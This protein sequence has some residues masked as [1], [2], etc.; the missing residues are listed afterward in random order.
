M[1]CTNPLYALIL[2]KSKE[3]GKYK[4]RFLPRR[5]DTNLA[6]LEE[7]YGLDN[8][9]R[10][11]CGKC[12]SCI[13]TYRKNWSV[14]CKLEA[15]CHLQNCFVTLTY[16][17]SHYNENCANRKEDLQKFIHA[18][19]DSGI[20]FRY[21]ACGELGSS[22][23]RFHYHMIMFGYFPSD[24]KPLGKKLEGMYFKSDFLTRKWNKGMVIVTEMSE[25]CA[26]YVAG[27]VN[28]KTSEL[29]KQNFILMST[30]PGIAFDY[31]LS[32]KEEMLEYGVILG[33]KGAVHFIPKYGNRVLEGE[34]AL[35]LFKANNMVDMRVSEDSLMR[36]LNV[37]VRE[38]TFLKRDKDMRDK[39]LKRRRVL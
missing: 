12:A 37:D 15:K 33:D 17:N 26:E 32:H 4:L 18:L 1:S 21:F 19:R 7:R 10:I 38:K 39:L 30:R 28:K 5:V 36:E 11:P 24:A 29:D 13:L 35:E 6:Y 8:L 20:N 22:S 14:R 31:F 34:P 9:V 3:T 2:G 23:G 27:Y 25:G 16:D